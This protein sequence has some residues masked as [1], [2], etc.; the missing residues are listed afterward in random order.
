MNRKVKLR[1]YV[2]G[3]APNER[4]RSRD[5]Q[6][7]PARFPRNNPAALSTSEP[8]QIPTTYRAVAATRRSARPA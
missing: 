6:C 5:I 3:S 2:T 1:L 8:V 7:V 4:N